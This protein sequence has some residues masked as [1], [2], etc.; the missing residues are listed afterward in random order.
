MGSAKPRLLSG[1]VGQGR[2]MSVRMDGLPLATDSGLCSTCLSLQLHPQPRQSVWCDQM[3]ALLVHGILDPSNARG[4]RS[5]NLPH[6][7]L[8]LWTHAYKRDLAVS[9]GY[10]HGH[11]FICVSSRFN[12]E[13]TRCHRALHIVPLQGSLSGWWELR[14]RIDGQPLRSMRIRLL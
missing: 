9:C 12:R 6:G 5:R 3:R 2:R 1:T 10:G 13:S 11:R 4:M 7:L 14:R 8:T